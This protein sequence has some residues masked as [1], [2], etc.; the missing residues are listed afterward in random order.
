MVN[1]TSVA[2]VVLLGGVHRGLLRED[3]VT[4]MRDVADLLR[5]QGVRLTPA[6]E[7]DLEELRESIAF[8]E[9]SDL[10]QSR[11]DHRGEILHFEA[12]RRRALDI[13]RNSIAHFLVIPS[14]LSRAVLAGLGRDYV[15][16]E[17]EI[18]VDVFYRE[19]Y[20]SRELYLTRGEA[21]LEHFESEGWVELEGDQWVTTAEG[22]RPLSIL[23]EQTR[24]V[25]ECYDTIVRVVLAWM[26]SVE[27]GVLR[28]GLIKEAQSAFESAQLLGYSRRAEALSDTTLDN[29][30]SWLVSRSI[31]DAKVIRTGKRNTH[32]TRYARG[33][34]WADL[35]EIQRLLASALRDG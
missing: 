14:L 3:L 12:N 21:V 6:F 34:K 17:L 31:L 22:N 35:E 30:L 26:E 28:S 1:A 13:Y 5:L 15:H 29:A 20:A 19:Y 2:A 8:L 27:E 23:A 11:L 24:G 7:R 10:L 4:G 16:Q 25:V 33:E 32:D 9:R 18:W